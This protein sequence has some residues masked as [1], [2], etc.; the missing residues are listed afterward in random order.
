MSPAGLLPSPFGGEPVQQRT[1]CYNWR[2]NHSFSA[3]DWPCI[4]VAAG[5]RHAKSST[6]SSPPSPSS[7]TVG[8]G[9]HVSTRGVPSHPDAPR[10]SWFHAQPNKANHSQ[11]CECRSFR[12]PRGCVLSCRP[13]PS[14][15]F[16]GGQ[17]LIHEC[18]SSFAL[19]TPHGPASCRSSPT[20]PNRFSTVPTPKTQTS[21]VAA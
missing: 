2:A 4:S 11:K 18:P 20:R 5:R 12:R 15:A 17:G 3:H 14:E 6:A 9:G 16:S 19:I 21:H 13:P 1:Q 8:Q 7:P 10:V